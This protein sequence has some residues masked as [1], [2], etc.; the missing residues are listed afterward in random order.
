MTK[1]IQIQILSIR[2]LKR[3][4]PVLENVTGALDLF[5]PWSFTFVNNFSVL[6]NLLPLIS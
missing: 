5:T 2:F 3:K 4:L 6:V 1:I